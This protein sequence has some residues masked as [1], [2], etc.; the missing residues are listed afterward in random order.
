MEMIYFKRVSWA[1]NSI[2]NVV[3]NRNLS[4]FSY[5]KQ[6]Q[7]FHRNFFSLKGSKVRKWTQISGLN[8]VKVL[9][10]TSI[11]FLMRHQ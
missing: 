2:K 3:G 5:N 11:K 6:S 1:E 9:E 4:Q 8:K 7:L 10:L